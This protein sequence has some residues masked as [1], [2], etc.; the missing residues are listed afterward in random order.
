MYI[1]PE[2]KIDRLLREGSF[3]LWG[4]SLPK[5]RIINETRFPMREYITSLVD[6]DYI[7]LTKKEF[8]FEWFCLGVMVALGIF[9][10]IIM[11]S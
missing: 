6:D 9:G 7:I 11:L 2:D 8:M 3:G 5:Y 1:K 4:L 10:L